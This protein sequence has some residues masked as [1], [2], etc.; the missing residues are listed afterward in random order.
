[1]VGQLIVGRFP[2]S[3]EGIVASR[4]RTLSTHSTSFQQ[5][6]ARSAHVATEDLT[7]VRLAFSNFDYTNISDSG[8]GALST[9]TAS[10]EYPAGTF[11]QLLFSGSSSS[12]IPS[13]DL[14]FSDY[15]TV[16][17]PNGSTFWVR[18]FINNSVGLFFN[19]WRNTFYGEATAVATSGL[20]DQTMSGTI[21]DTGQGWSLPPTAILGTTI[22][23]SVII[24]GDSISVGFGGGGQPQNGALATGFNG[25]Q[26]IVAQ[27]LGNIPF[28]NM[29]VPGQTATSW[30]AQATARDK[31]IQKGSHL[32]VQV[33]VNDLANGRT[34]AQIITSLQGIY[35]LARSGQKIYQTTI[36]PDS[37]STDSWAT[38]VNQT[39]VPNPTTEYAALN[40]AIRA[41]LANT[42]GTYDV[43]SVV[44][45]SLNSSLWP[46][47]GA[48]NF[49]TSDGLH[50]SSVGYNAVVSN[51]IIGP[52]T[53]P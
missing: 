6:M 23:P 14:I 12:S 42:T 32:I 16:S 10:I 11:T 43:T 8:N 18:Q 22:N 41:I 49:A 46:V 52:I 51:N 48:A 4:A 36:T 24:A 25:K 20:T 40:T 31:L 29:G 45:N 39:T 37:T 5:I 26:G 3:Y 15:V 38:L 21:S 50:P 35:A 28:L 13:G 30:I 2:F 1:M 27:S 34:S 44:E 33:G 53:W 17:I 47:T 19:G 9:I 7:S